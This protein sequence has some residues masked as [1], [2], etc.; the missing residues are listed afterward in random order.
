MAGLVLAGCVYPV[1]DFACAVATALGMVLHQR[2]Y[3]LGGPSSR[4]RGRKQRP[5]KARPHVLPERPRRCDG[6]GLFVQMRTIVFANN[7]PFTFLFPLAGYG[8]H[9]AGFAVRLLAGLLVDGLLLVVA[10]KG[11]GT[12]SN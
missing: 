3:A 11:F 5:V 10:V 2:G 12:A 4:P 7:A 8:K 1:H 6:H 9:G